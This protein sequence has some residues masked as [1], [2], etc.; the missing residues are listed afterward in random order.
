MNNPESEIK[1]QLRSRITETVSIQIPTDTLESLK[2]IAANWNR[3]AV[4]GYNPV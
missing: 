4:I 2:K 1:L 3:E